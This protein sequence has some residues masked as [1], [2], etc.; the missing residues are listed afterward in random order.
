V[1]L[2]TTSERATP[3]TFGTRASM[4]SLAARG[5]LLAAVAGA[6]ATGSRAD[7]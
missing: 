1:N 2:V 6:D 3:W 7:D 5:L 4:R